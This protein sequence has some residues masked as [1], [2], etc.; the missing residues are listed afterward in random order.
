MNI[1]EVIKIINTFNVNVIFDDLINVKE[2]ILGGQSI[3]YFTPIEG[4]EKPWL[5]P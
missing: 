5:L 3:F 2:K 4:K 1:S